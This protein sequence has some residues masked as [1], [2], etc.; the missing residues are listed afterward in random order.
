MGDT[1]VALSHARNG[2]TEIGIRTSFDAFTVALGYTNGN[3]TA[4]AGGWAANTPVWALSG[5]YDGG[6][7]GVGVLY[8]T[9]DGVVPGT[10]NA[11]WSI[12]GS[13]EL[14]GGTAYAFIGDVAGASTYGV[15]YSYSLGGGASAVAGLEHN[16]AGAGT[17]VASIG[18]VFNF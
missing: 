14:G 12:S 8:A 4:A 16:S 18:A 9:G 11:N 17:T 7:W 10:T 15:N 2:A 5:H 1:R 3:N 13:A 6:S